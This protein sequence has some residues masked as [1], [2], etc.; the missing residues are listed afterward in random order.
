[1][2]YDYSK[3]IGLPDFDKRVSLISS[4][5]GQIA[6]CHKK[7]VKDPY[8]GLLALEWQKKIDKCLEGLPLAECQGK[9]AVK[10][11]KPFTKK[12]RLAYKK[13]HQKE[14]REFRQKQKRLNEERNKNVK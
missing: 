6:Y 8:F 1:M 14:I 10:G 2:E 11:K 4:W 12:Q 7:K 5:K 13:E 9:V 3:I